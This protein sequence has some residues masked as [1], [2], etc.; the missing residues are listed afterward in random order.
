MKIKEVIE[1]L[2]VKKK[3]LNDNSKKYISE[4]LWSCCEQCGVS[5]VRDSSLIHHT[6][7]KI[8]RHLPM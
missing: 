6:L 8:Y 7:L 4:F 3:K 1:D 2:K 5:S